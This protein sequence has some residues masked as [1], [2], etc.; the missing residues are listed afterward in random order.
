MLNGLYVVNPNWETV[1][2]TGEERNVAAVRRVFL[3]LFYI[4]VKR[5]TCLLESLSVINTASNT[6]VLQSQV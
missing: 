6:P 3:F 4:D 5:T 1:K 2:P